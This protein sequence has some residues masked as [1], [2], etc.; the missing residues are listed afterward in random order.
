[1]GETA[2]GRLS[3]LAQRIFLASCLQYLWSG[4]LL[5]YSTQVC[6][7]SCTTR[8]E[9]FQECGPL[10][11]S[12]LDRGLLVWLSPCIVSKGARFF[13]KFYFVVFVVVVHV[14]EYFSCIA[15]YGCRG[16]FFVA[17][18]A[19]FVWLLIDDFD[20]FM[21]FAICLAFVALGL[22]CLGYAWI[23]TLSHTFRISHMM[24]FDLLKTMCKD[25]KLL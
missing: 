5:S 12:E 18:V 25:N 24:L 14:L 11:N 4:T 9:D 17:F 13:L 15:L 20:G 3:L 8:G 21:A 19:S 10:G 1:M 16:M 22:F 7:W 23:L 2:N 6:P